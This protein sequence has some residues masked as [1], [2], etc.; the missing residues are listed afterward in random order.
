MFQ[1][2]Y[3]NCPYKSP[4]DMGVNMAGFAIVDNDVVEKASK[5]EIIRRYLNARVD[6]KNAKI[7]FE[8]LEKAHGLLQKVGIDENEEIIKIMVVARKNSERTNN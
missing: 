6:Y 3:G 4:T 7:S 5:D 1:A 8:T 2:I